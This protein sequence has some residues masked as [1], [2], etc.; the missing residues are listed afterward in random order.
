MSLDKK[1]FFRYDNK[2]TNDQKQ[3]TSP[4]VKKKKKLLK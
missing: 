2:I 3:L 4:R 1:K